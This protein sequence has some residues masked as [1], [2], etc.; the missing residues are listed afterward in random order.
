MAATS[1]RHRTCAD[2]WQLALPPEHRHPARSIIAAI[3]DADHLAL[4][5]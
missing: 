1:G 5:G 4:V 3:A 2:C